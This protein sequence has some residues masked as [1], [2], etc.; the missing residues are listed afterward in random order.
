MKLLNEELWDG[1]MG[2]G[3]S[4]VRSQVSNHGYMHVYRCVAAP[5]EWLVYWQVYCEVARQLSGDMK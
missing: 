3:D 4:V 1:P 2:A 5:V